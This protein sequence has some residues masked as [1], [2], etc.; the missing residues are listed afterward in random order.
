MNNKQ[1]IHLS[2]KT[3][4]N[5]E[6]E[7]GHYIHWTALTHHIILWLTFIFQQNLPYPML[8]KVHKARTSFPVT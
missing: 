4:A 7:I 6:F 2:A 5:V 3:I 1:A 8:P